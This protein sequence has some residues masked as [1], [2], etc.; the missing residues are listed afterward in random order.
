MIDS[1]TLDSD[2]RF[3]THCET[4]AELACDA[5]PLRQLANLCIDDRGDKEQQIVAERKPDQPWTLPSERQRNETER[6]QNVEEA[7]EDEAHR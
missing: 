6:G 5:K 3:S 7:G 4:A 1:E 2:F